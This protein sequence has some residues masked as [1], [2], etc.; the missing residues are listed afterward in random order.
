V[1]ARAKARVRIG[2]GG[3]GG[4][5]EKSSSGVLEVVEA[6]LGFRDEPD[7]RPPRV[8][9]HTDVSSM[10]DSYEVSEQLSRSTDLL[11]IC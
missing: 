3:P 10:D 11:Q 1:A 4:V 7:T 8:P 5:D 2:P 6:H 9:V